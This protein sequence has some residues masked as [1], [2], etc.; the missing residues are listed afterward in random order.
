MTGHRSWARLFEPVPGSR[1]AALAGLTNGVAVGFPLLVG[2]A[3]G[4]PAAGALACLGAYVAA[5]TNKGGPRGQRT[6]GLAVAGAVNALA[7]WAGELVTD[8]FPL[9]LALLTALVFLA[10]M[11]QAVHGT[12]ARLG[13]MP[14]TALLAGAGQAGSDAVGTV[15]AFLLVLAGGLWYAAATGLLTPVPRLRSVLAAVAEPFR[16]TGRHLDRIAAASHRPGGDHARAVAALRRAE[17][18]A[19]ALHGPDGDEYLASL[20]APLLRQASVLVDL[21]AALAE[22]GAPPQ[23]VLE[24]FT[25][26]SRA[27]ADQIAQVAGL[28]TRRPGRGTSLKDMADAMATLTLACDRLR[29]RAATGQEPYPAVAK[30]GRQRRLLARIRTA[31]G[32]AHHHARTLRGVAGTRIHPAPAPQAPFDAA[33]LRATMTFSSSAYRHALRV[34]A[35]AAAVFTLVWAARLPHGEWA[36][37]AVLRVLRPQYGATLERAGQ[38]ITGNLVGGTCA[39]LIIAGVKEPALLAVMLFAVISAGFALRP[40]NYAFWV[41]FG[42]PLVLLIGDVTQPGDWGSALER[43]AMT[44]LGSV[45]A[46][47]GGYLLW[48]TWDH[49][50][51]T[52]QTTEATRAVAAYLD[53][54]LNRLTHPRSPST[55]QTRRRAESI[56]AKAQT[57]QQHARREPGHDPRAVSDASTTLAVL[58]TL[59]EHLTALTAHSTRQAALIPGLSDY[60]THAPAAL[61]APQADERT[62]HAAAL[63]DALDDMRLYLEGLHTQ[64]LRELATRPD[65]DTHVRR[66]IRDDEPVIGLLT[67]IQSCIG[68]LLRQPA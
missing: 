62:A 1:P 17:Q 58:A 37:L 55:D 22:T 46:L 53:A 12:V 35:V 41:V 36:T 7:F 14:A 56:L 10:A 44:V 26:A 5:F 54:A 63:A 39:A 65:G 64:R 15:R 3:A 4:D 38:R 68:R 48:P 59:M 25:A 51:L 8:L 52:E 67:K 18:A 31:T 30:A 45:A 43:I 28:L 61:T 57:S 40:V 33:R 27:L 34:T 49:D 60:G 2:V 6:A 21:T 24:P 66:T 20:V 11:G 32:T 23:A 47:L 16:E 19:Q 50:R 13:T 9:A 42:T 29:S